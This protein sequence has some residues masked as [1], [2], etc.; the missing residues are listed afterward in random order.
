ML[1][2]AINELGY[3]GTG[4]L[5]SVSSTVRKEAESLGISSTLSLKKQLDKIIEGRWQFVCKVNPVK[6]TVQIRTIYVKN[7]KPIPFILPDN[8]TLE[9]R[10][11][12]PMKIKRE[13]KNQFNDQIN[14]RIIPHLR[15][16]D[17]DIQSKIIFRMEATMKDTEG[18]KS[19]NREVHTRPIMVRLKSGADRN[20]FF[21]Q[22]EEQWEQTYNKFSKFG[23]ERKNPEEWIINIEE[24]VLNPEVEMNRDDYNNGNSSYYW[25]L[26]SISSFTL[27]IIFPFR[28][29]NPND[30]AQVLTGP[31]ETFIDNKLVSSEEWE[32][33]VPDEKEVENEK[34]A[35]PRQSDGRNKRAK[36]KARANQHR[37]GFYFEPP[38]CLKHRESGVIVIDNKNEYCFKYA[39][40]ASLHYNDKHREHPKRHTQ[41]E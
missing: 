14:K 3:T 32:E 20:R 12:Y 16:R 29:N 7:N 41:Y 6:D 22:V 35:N 24:D 2:N 18:E 31:V 4:L 8:L 39:V 10:K 38:D 9:Q 13:L 5:P 15:R 28:E 25:F 21:Q 27:D 19:V 40:C 17:Y 11:N 1:E 23:T 34:Y 36:A 30:E 33:Q 37:G 26:Y